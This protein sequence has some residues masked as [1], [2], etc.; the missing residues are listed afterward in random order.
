MN[1]QL[2]SPALRVTLCFS[3]ERSQQVEVY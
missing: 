3:R 2:E 1:E